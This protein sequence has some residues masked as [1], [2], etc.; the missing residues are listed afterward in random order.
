MR[1]E[2]RCETVLVLHQYYFRLAKEQ[3]EMKLMTYRDSCPELQTSVND[4]QWKLMLTT[5]DLVSLLEELS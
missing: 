5:L 3:R 4:F 2:L 1:R